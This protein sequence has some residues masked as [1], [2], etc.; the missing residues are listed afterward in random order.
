MYRLQESSS[1]GVWAQVHENTDD[2]HEAPFLIKIKGVG[3]Y[4]AK[5]N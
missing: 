3:R 2:E 1:L 5:P 4:P